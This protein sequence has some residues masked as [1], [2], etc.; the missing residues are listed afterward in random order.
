ML[1]SSRASKEMEVQWKVM[2]LKK[3]FYFPLSSTSTQSHKHF[4]NSLKVILHTDDTTVTN[5]PKHTHP[6]NF[7]FNKGWEDVSDCPA[8]SYTVSSALC[9]V[10]FQCEKYFGGRFRKRKKKKNKTWRSEGGEQKALMLVRKCP[11]VQPYL[12]LSV[13]KWAQRESLLL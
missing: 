10:K 1:N 11:K 4:L 3:L 6:P 12:W 5:L 7:G 8:Q 9:C 2:H 13:V